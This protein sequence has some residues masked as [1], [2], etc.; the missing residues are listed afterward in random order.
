Y[1]ITSRIGYTLSIKII[2]PRYNITNQT[3]YMEMIAYDKQYDLN[4]MPL[5]GQQIQFEE[6]LTLKNT[7][8]FGQPRNDI[9]RYD[10]V[11]DRCIRHALVPDVLSYFGRQKYTD[12][13]YLDSHISTVSTANSDLRKNILINESWFITVLAF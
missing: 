9:A 10:W 13:P 11:F 3:D 1:D 8:F 6:T 5:S 12:I 7:Y 2:D 4:I